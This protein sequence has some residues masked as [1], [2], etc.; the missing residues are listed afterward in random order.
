MQLQTVWP[1]IGALVVGAITPGPNNFM[2]MQASVH[3]GIAAAGSVMLGV[4]LGSLGLLALISF[5]VGSA[6]RTYP[7]LGFVLS[8]VGGGYLAWLGAASMFQAPAEVGAEARRGTPT[9]LWGIAA[10]QLLNPKAWI[11]IMT[12]VAAVSDNFSVFALA[13]LIMVVSGVCLSVWAIAGSASARLLAAPH[14][15][16]WFDRTMGSLL[17][18]SGMGIAIDAVA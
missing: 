14:A 17:L 10:F 9:S 16:L 8:V 4:S 5:G 13:I 3:G 1:V 11:L 6:I 2:V 12:A 15:K 18:I 7:E